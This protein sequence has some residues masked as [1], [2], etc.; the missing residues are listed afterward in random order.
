MKGRETLNPTETKKKTR[1]REEKVSSSPNEII[2]TQSTG[3]DTTSLQEISTEQAGP[4]IG[5]GILT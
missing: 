4:T 2:Q 5:N 1:D 3:R